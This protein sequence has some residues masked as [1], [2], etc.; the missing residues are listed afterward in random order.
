LLGYATGI[1]VYL[2]GR[3]LPSFYAVRLPGV[4]FV[5]GLSGWTNNGW[6]EAASFDLMSRR[7]VERAWVDRGLAHLQR[8]VHCDAKALAGAIDCELPEATAI[9]TQLCRCGRAVYDVEARDFRHRELFA[10]PI[11]P[12]SFYPPDPRVAEANDFIARGLARIDNEEVRRREKVAPA[13]DPDDPPRVTVFENRVVQGTVENRQTHIVIQ[14]TGRI[15]FGRC[16]CPFF[17]ENLMNKG[18]CAH[19]LA[20]HEVAS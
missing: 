5:L 11:D 19:M 15:I 1:D 18:P 17:D 3:A 2:K 6:T 8:V 13:T 12:E 4:T 9:L 10:D 7:T 14:D 16:T 20:L